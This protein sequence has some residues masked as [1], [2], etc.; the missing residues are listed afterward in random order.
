MSSRPIWPGAAE[1]KE[2]VDAVCRGIAPELKRAG[3]RKSARTWRRSHDRLTQ[4]VNVQA[5]PWNTPARDFVERTRARLTLNVGIHVGGLDTLIG[6]STPTSP[7]AINRCHID[8]R[9]GQLMD[10]RDHWWDMSTLRDV[11]GIVGELEQ[12]LAQVVFPWMD[13]HASLDAV[14]SWFAN[15]PSGAFVLIKARDQIGHLT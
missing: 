14:K 2:L 4:V 5:S 1:P 10:G 6:W 11:E 9:V 12:L 13:D 7:P 8:L 3:F 15:P